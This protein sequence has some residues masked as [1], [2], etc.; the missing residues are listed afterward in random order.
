MAL[1]HAD[2][3]CVSI[4]GGVEHL[5]DYNVRAAKL[6][7]QQWHPVILK[8]A[9]EEPCHDGVDHL[10]RVEGSLPSR[11]QPW[12]WVRPCKYLYRRPEA[13][14]SR[15]YARREKELAVP[16]RRSRVDLCRG[17]RPSRS[18]RLRE[19]AAH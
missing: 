12:G 8:A 4:F 10:A 14:G 18:H 19:R 16:H 6:P 7:L 1:E 17:E 13:V 3:F 2:A 11:A 5:H 15:H 9:F